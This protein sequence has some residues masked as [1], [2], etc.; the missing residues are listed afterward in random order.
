[1]FFGRSYADINSSNSPSGPKCKLLCAARR[2]PFIWTCVRYQTLSQSPNEEQI[3]VRCSHSHAGVDVSDSYDFLSNSDVDRT[4][5]ICDSYSIPSPFVTNALFID[6]RSAS[7]M[8]SGRKDIQDIALILGTSTGHVRFLSFNAA[9]DYT[10]SGA[11]V[12]IGSI[13]VFPK[14]S[15][16]HIFHPVSVVSMST[17]RDMSVFTQLYVLHGDSSVTQLE[18]DVSDGISSYSASS[19]PRSRRWQ[20]PFCAKAIVPIPAPPLFPA[21]V[22]PGCGGTAAGGP[23]AERVDILVGGKTPVLA[24]VSSASPSGSSAA[25][26]GPSVPIS[27]GKAFLSVAGWL[28]SSAQSQQ[29][30]QQQQQQQGGGRDSSSSSQHLSVLT[31]LNDPPREILSFSPS[32]SYQYVAAADTLGRV[33]IVDVAEAC[34]IIRIFK[35]YRDAQCAWLSKKSLPKNIYV[36]GKDGKDGNNDDDDDDDDGKDEKDEKEEKVDAAKGD[37]ED[38]EGDELCKM[39]LAIYTPV[40]SIVDLW[41]PLG[42][43]PFRRIEVDPKYKIAPLYCG[44]VADNLVFFD[45][46][47]GTATPLH[48]FILAASL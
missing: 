44:N 35:G 27:L 30:S 1:M 47:N 28:L 24:M 23:G 34:L 6:H 37:D 22:P 19:L 16:C 33:S 39:V 11:S 25:E 46:P 3:S 29:D 17:A 13:H 20:V 40:Q 9:I 4:T 48:E 8:G 36:N 26:K 43:S 45:A 7:G 5:P 41:D 31:E 2:G 38:E 12:K 15:F 32:P 10:Q 42:Q 21:V 18:L 14:S